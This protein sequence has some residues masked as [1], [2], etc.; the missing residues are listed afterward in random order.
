[1][2]DKGIIGGSTRRKLGNLTLFDSWV[3]E[4]IVRWWGGQLRR[5]TFDLSGPPKAGPLEGR[6]RRTLT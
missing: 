3:P 1:M 6:V 5:L 4:F 2:N